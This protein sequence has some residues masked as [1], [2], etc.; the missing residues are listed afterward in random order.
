M[1]N[2]MEEAMKNIKKVDNK[3]N[4]VNTL[5][6][7][8]FIDPKL[9]TYIVPSEIRN[10]SKTKS[11]IKMTSGS[12]FDI[13]LKEFKF[14]RVFTA[15]GFLKGKEK[16]LP[17]DVDLSASFINEDGNLTSL[18]YFN[19]EEDFAVHS[20]DWTSCGKWNEKK[21][22]TEFIDID[23]IKAKKTQRY[24]LISNIFFNSTFDKN[25]YI[26]HGLQFLNER[27]SVKQFNDISDA[28]WNINLNQGTGEN[29]NVHAS[30]LIDLKEEKI[31]IVDKYFSSSQFSNISSNREILDIYK[32]KFL[33]NTKIEMNMYDLIEL[34]CKSNKYKMVKDK[35]KSNL[36][37]SYLNDK[38]KETFNVSDNLEKILSLYN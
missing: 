1:F 23:L 34:Y 22:T 24:V 30:I 38:E 27:K 31:I 17:I 8:V 7:K 15:W 28:Y 32:E 19:Q 18:S 4:K 20:G 11:G 29:N 37:I 2:T 21:V 12:S 35:E 25:I 6:K 5:N 26:E 13:D 14:L 3:V 33:N 9:K 16:M 36:I 10:L